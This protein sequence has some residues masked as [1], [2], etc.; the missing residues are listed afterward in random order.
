TQQHS[1]KVASFCELLDQNLLIKVEHSYREGNRA[2]DY[3][4]GHGHSLPLGVHSISSSDPTLSNC[5]YTF[6]ITCLGF[7]KLV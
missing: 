1:S 2:A 3:L 5:L 4:V 7:S 6:C